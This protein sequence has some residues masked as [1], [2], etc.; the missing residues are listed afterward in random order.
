[1]V[2]PQISLFLEVATPNQRN[3]S[4]PAAVR[5]STKEANLEKIKLD[6]FKFSNPIKFWTQSP[7]IRTTTAKKIR[8]QCLT[9]LPPPPHFSSLGVSKMTAA[10]RR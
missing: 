1:M 5:R 3:C 2:L 8:L 4:S 10:A 6:F 7:I 9:N